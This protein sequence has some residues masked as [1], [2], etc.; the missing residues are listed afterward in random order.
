MQI[1]LT[2]LY[3]GI[4]SFAI[5]KWN[6]T[7]KTN[8]KPKLLTAIFLSKVLAGLLLVLL[9]TFY[10]TNRQTAD[11]YNYFDDGNVLYSA[12]FNNPVDYLRMLTGIGSDSE[13]LMK[14]YN[15]MGFWIKNFDYNL[16]ND[17]RTMIRL[18]AFIRI[19][20][21]GSIYVH[22]V[23]FAFFSFVGLTA[24]YRVF[25]T[26]FNN[27]K[28][29]LI[30][31]VYFIPS[32]I[33]W[34]SG[35]LKESVLIMGFGSLIYSFYEIVYR[36][37]SLKYV[38][39]LILSSFILFFTKF[40][41]LI[42]VLPGLIT[43]LLFKITKHKYQ[44]L[45]FI[46]IHAILFVILFNSHHIL[47]RYHFAEIMAN[48]Q[49]DFIAYVDSL[50]DV[51]SKIK[52]SRLEPTMKSILLNAPKAF[53]NSFLRPFLWEANSI[54][55]LFS[56]FENTLLFILL[57]VSLI[58]RKKHFKPDD[59]HYLCLS[60]VLI[61][62]ILTGLTTPVLGALVRYKTPALP[63]LVILL[64]CITDFNRI[65]NLIFRK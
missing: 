46:V 7:R 40:Y 44:S 54:T 55:S 26:I 35:P 8:L 53:L 59:L 41:I 52:I 50:P 19:F 3:T 23:F 57:I 10:Y 49:K 56:A 14:Y 1:L 45:K 64:F 16:F 51:G 48:K 5:V 62:F 21:F 37:I 22:S 33:L 39:I 38:L 30:V 15:E 28:Y 4:F 17:N 12:L 36:R 65:N 2:I 60:F 58:F 42:S 6:F 20:S 11:V 34:T 18:N 13:H 63:L 25:T 27:A 32:V 9:Y 43:L 61:L 31:A 47:P 29:L 24:I